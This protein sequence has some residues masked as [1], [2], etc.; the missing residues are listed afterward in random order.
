MVAYFYFIW[1]LLKKTFCGEQP[2]RLMLVSGEIAF[3]ELDLDSFYGTG[4]FLA[5]LFIQEDG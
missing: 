1:W 5:A 4:S 3:R 2:K